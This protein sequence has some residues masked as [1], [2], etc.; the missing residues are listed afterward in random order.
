MNTA[1]T[2]WAYCEIPGDTFVKV[3]VVGGIVQWLSEGRA[4]LDPWENP[5]VLPLATTT[6]TISRKGIFQI[7]FKLRI[8]QLKN[9]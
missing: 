9:E 4:G 7:T 5:A 2:A 3:R 6:C 8:L 1:A